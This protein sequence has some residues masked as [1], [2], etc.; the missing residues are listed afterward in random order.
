MS[1]S[2][3]KSTLILPSFTAE[4]TMEVFVEVEAEAMRD[5]MSNVELE[6]E[7]GFPESMS[8]CIEAM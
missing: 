7:T 6:I 8:S 2:M 1:S 5:S 4:E 3:T